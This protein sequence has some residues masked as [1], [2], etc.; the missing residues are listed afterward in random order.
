[1][2]SLTESELDTVAS[3]SNSV[4]LALFGVS[5]GAF[6]SAIITAITV[7]LAPIAFAGFIAASITTGLFTLFFGSSS[8]KS[9]REA[10]R[11]INELKC[12]KRN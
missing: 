7:P 9:Y 6:I 11:K 4:H 8:Y 10:R 2:Y 3:L 1:M 5:G 12:G